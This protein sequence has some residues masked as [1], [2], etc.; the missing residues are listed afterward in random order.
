MYFYLASDRLKG[1][2]VISAI[3]F[4]FVS[5]WFCSGYITYMKGH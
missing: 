4:E 5:D 1:F 3:K 2:A